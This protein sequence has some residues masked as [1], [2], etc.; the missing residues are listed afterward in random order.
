MVEPVHT[1]SLRRGKDGKDTLLYLHR[2]DALAEI[3]PLSD[4][5]ARSLALDGVQWV[6]DEMRRG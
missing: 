5:A 3:I 2:K 1:A 6:V 4:E